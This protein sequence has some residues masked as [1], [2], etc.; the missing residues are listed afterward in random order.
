MLLEWQFPSLV[1]DL[2]VNSITRTSL[3]LATGMKG[4]KEI[5]AL[6]SLP[7]ILVQATAFH[8]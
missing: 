6:L 7:S 5:V 4:F 8:P 3:L 1:V 2:D